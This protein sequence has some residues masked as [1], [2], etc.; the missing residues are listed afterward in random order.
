MFLEPPIP[1]QQ[2][3]LDTTGFI[4]VGAYLVSLLLVGYL[5]NRA[6]R[7][8]SLKDYYLAGSSL[9]TFALFFT[10]YAT[11][12]SGNTMLAMPGQAYR[13]GFAGMAMLFAMMG[14]I[15]VYGLF[16]QGLRQLAVQHQFIS[17]G[18]F[19]R[20]RYS[21][22]LLLALV[23][24][25]AVVV[26]LSYALGNLKAVGILLSSASG[27]QISFVSG[28]L[29][30]SAI[31]AIYESMGGMRGVVWTDVIQGSLLFLGCLLV[32]AAV[33][34]L[35]DAQS[36]LSPP[37]FMVSFGHYLTS[38]A[39]LPGMLSLIVLV[40][41]GAAVYPQAIQRIYA[42]RDGRT[43]SRSYLGMFFM[44]LL[45]T[46][47]M[48]LVGM[49]VA[50]LYPQLSREQ[51]E[52]AV[53]Y[54]I[55]SVVQVYP[56][57][58]AL[59]ILYI[60]AAVAAIMSTI[61]SALLSLGSIVTRDIFAHEEAQAAHS[62]MA[63]RMTSLVLMALLAVLA[64]YLPNNLWG[65]LVFKMELLV[66][67]A[68]LVILGV[69]YPQLNS[70]AVLPGLLLGSCVALLLKSSV[71]WGTEDLSKYWGIHAGVWGLLANVATV[72][73]VTKL[74]PGDIKIMKRKKQVN[75]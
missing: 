26:L 6:S 56:W 58:S 15:L 48:I 55:E 41:F 8:Q 36:I 5:A 52:Q 64:I 16:A 75:L 27:G 2:S 49:R 18:D 39:N 57:L 71:F 46:L 67:L 62:K 23:N 29:L 31:M 51:S 37:V 22:P 60:A 19:V 28:V 35:R 9:G 4:V 50:E 43:L 7:E 74:M 14:V 61:D 65:L 21:Q 40:A 44:P 3:L 66:Q 53:V 11:Q 45:T 42:A 32:F 54:A 1:M 69:R 13:Q 68:P 12:Y 38:E 20:W 17:L 73:L 24:C 72:F 47:P 34:S 25:I 33:F 30:L 59:L 70:A 10:L 63:A